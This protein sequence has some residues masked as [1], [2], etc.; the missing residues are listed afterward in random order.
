VFEKLLPLVVGWGLFILILYVVVFRYQRRINYGSKV[1]KRCA[2]VATE[3]GRENEIV[4]SES[5]S[6]TLSDVR[7]AP[8]AIKYL[9]WI[10]VAFFVSFGLVNAVH[11]FS[12][13]R[14]TPDFAVYELTY[15]ALSFVSKA[16]LTIYVMSAVLGGELAWLQGLGSA[17]E[18]SRCIQANDTR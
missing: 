2:T 13:F 11:V 18:P 4:E 9:I 16:F 8:A 7:A 3:E 12:S 17:D 14:G 5:S 15:V 6:S 1:A 10:V